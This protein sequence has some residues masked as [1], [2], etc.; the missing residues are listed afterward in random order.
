MLLHY[1]TEPFDGN[2]IQEVMDCYLEFKNVPLSVPGQVRLD[3]CPKV[4]GAVC[5]RHDAPYIP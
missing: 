2:L 5:G 1:L 4:I 3:I